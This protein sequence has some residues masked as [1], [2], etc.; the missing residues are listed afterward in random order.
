M[1]EDRGFTE[2]AYI[3]GGVTPLKSAGMAR[4]MKERVSGMDIPDEVIRR[5]E[6]VPKG[7]QREEGIRICVETISRLKEL[8]GVRGVHIMAIEWEAAVGEIADQ[9]GLLPRPEV[10]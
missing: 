9:A 3:L 4:Y 1:A 10:G 8:P 7:N 6:G 2:K 5:M